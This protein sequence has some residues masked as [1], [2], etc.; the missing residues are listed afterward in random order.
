[1][2][3]S[4][5]IVFD[6]ERSIRELPGSLSARQLLAKNG[7]EYL[8]N[9][10]LSSANDWELKRQLATAYLRMGEVQGGSSDGNLGNPASALVSL[11]RAQA[12]LDAV[13]QNNP[14]HRAA[15]LEA[16]LRRHA[17]IEC[18]QHEQDFVRIDGGR[19]GERV[20]GE[21]GP[22]LLLKFILSDAVLFQIRLP[23]AHDAALLAVRDDV[24]QVASGQ[25]DDG[26]ANPRIQRR[27]KRRP[28]A[29]HAD[30]KDANARSIQ[31]GPRLNPVHGL[32][33]VDGRLPQRVI[34]F[35]KVIER[36]GR[37]HIEIDGNRLLMYVAERTSTDRRRELLDRWYR[38]QLRQAIPSVVAEWEPKI[39]VTVPK[40]SIRRMKTKWGSC[41]R[42]SGHI[43]FNVELAKKHPECL[44]YLAVHEMTHLVERSHGERFTKLMDRSMYDWRARRDR[45]N[46]APLGHEQWVRP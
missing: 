40:W 43:W 4:L 45:L 26:G 8:D 22:Q 10:A 27:K 37:A 7:I 11:Q 33:G 28:D 39:G 29:A 44:E 32:P 20:A 31:F 12:L 15:Q 41:N 24:G 2:R 30:A 17:V 6:V 14:N 23:A 36:P 25:A 1:M 9:L 18:R 46:E 38:A 16:L 35:L 13:I 21:R 19:H 34:D 3:A 5:T 42:V